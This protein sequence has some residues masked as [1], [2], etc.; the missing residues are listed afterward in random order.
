MPRA[1]WALALCQLCI[2]ASAWPA[3]AQ[4]RLDRGLRERLEKA[5]SAAGGRARIAGL[6][7]QTWTSKTTTP[8][9]DGP[10]EVVARHWV[11]WP[12]RYKVEVE[13]AYTLALAGETGWIRDAEGLNVLSRERVADLRE[14][15]YASWVRTLLPL[16]DKGF[17]LAPLP[18]IEVEGRRAWGLKVTHKGHREVRLYIDQESSLVSKTVTR[19]RSADNPERFDTLETIHVETG[20]SAGLKVV[21]KS[22]VYRNGKLIMEVENSNIERLATLDDAV[23]A[24]PEE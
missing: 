11:R 17:V 23:F 16:A 19:T 5:V 1:A 9:D 22:R 24:K 12:D 8:G 14:D 4:A 3:A 7:A 6:P 20:E 15:L 10:Q 18:E 2:L 13:G 21:R